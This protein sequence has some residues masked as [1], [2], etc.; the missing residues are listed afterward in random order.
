MTRSLRLTINRP[1]GSL[2]SPQSSLRRIKSIFATRLARG[3]AIAAS[4]CAG[5]FRAFSKFRLR[6]ERPPRSI[7]AVRVDHLGDAILTT[8]ALAALRNRFPAAEIAVVC[9]SWSADVFRGNLNIDSIIVLDCPWWIRNRTGR[10]GWRD[11]CALFHS[12]VA[13]RKS[14]FDL[15]IDFRGDPRHIFCFGVL[16]GIPCLAGIDRL[17]TGALL[18]ISS[19]PEEGTHEIERSLSVARA[20]GADKTIPPVTIPIADE[21]RR[22][23]EQLISNL[24][25]YLVFHTGGKTIN[26]WPIQHFVALLQNLL[27]RSDLNFVIVGGLE[28]GPD[29]DR[30]AELDRKR[31][32]VVVGQ[33]K[34]TSVAAIIERAAIYIGCDSGPMHILHAV[35][36][37]SVLLF[38]PTA[39]GRFAPCRA[40][41][42]I[43]RA[44]Q[45][46]RDDLHEICQRS[47][48]GTWSDCMASLPLEL[49]LASVN[50]E[51]DQLQRCKV[52]DDERGTVCR[53]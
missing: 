1:S 42:H 29:A 45:C 13:I 39:P 47:P 5:L 46:C 32:Y 18:D 38:G 7:L 12:I 53:N 27:V 37:P 2:E 22:I 31:V 48:D 24:G 33:L 30:L 20:L 17:G 25:R 10:A 8:P 4:Y 50:Q 43:V 41:T 34:I 16:T 9:A 15:M 36:T 44:S 23:V 21:D 40:R 11:Y 6:E 35:T 26:R 49:V 28:D 51:L 14:S 19:R 3:L 52:N